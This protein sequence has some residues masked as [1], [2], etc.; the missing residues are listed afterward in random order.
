M[1][2][3]LGVGALPVI[4][5]CH[6]PLQSAVVVTRASGRIVGTAPVADRSPSRSRVVP[7]AK[8]AGRRSGCVAANWPTGTQSSDLLLGSAGKQTSR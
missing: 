1:H 8:A 7:S 4:V 6:W 5:G 3:V 2:S